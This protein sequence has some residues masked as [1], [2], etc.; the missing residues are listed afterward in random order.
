LI[1]LSQIEMQT[2]PQSAVF[3]WLEQQIKTLKKSYK[4][5]WKNLITKYKKN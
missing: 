4:K 1:W 3:Q 2:A 5:K